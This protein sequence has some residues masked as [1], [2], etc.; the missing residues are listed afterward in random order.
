MATF[1]IVT[2]L[3]SFVYAL[4]LTHLLQ[5]ITDLLL[6]RERVRWSAVHAGW[7][8][9]A[10]VMLINNWLALIPLA[11]ADWTTP[12]IILMFALATIQY[13]TCAL[14]MPRIAEDRVVD[15]VAFHRR[16]GWLFILPYTVMLL[17]VM[18]LNF[19]FNDRYHGSVGGLGRFV[20]ESWPL[21]GL[22][23]LFALTCGG[24]RHGCARSRRSA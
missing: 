15:L 9:L 22:M 1:E 18:T 8:L 13:F 21:Y 7:M 23:A 2:A 16:N 14:L 11:E 20:A 6:N 24:A 12:V 19:H 5:G 10:L 4:A 17:P 3:L